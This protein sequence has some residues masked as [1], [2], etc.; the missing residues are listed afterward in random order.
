MSERHTMEGSTTMEL[1]WSLGWRLRRSMEDAGLKPQEMAR[2]LGVSRQTITRWTHDIGDPP[3]RAYLM[4][5]AAETEFPES[6][7]LIDPY[8]AVERRRG[9]ERRSGTR[10]AE[11]RPR[12]VSNTPERNTARSSR[13]R[14]P[15]TPPQQT[16]PGY[17]GGSIAA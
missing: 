9:I 12:A 5:W 1:D 8:P 14:R 7:L 2:R 6:F 17:Y 15:V 11:R 4:Q 16:R 3:K 13:L 10:T